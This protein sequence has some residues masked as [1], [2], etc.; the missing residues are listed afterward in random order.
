MGGLEAGLFDLLSNFKT[1]KAIDME[2][3]PK[4][5]NYKKFQFYL[6]LENVMILFVTY[7][8]TKF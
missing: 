3:W 6:F 4:V 8:V 1:S 5:N 7:D 2:V